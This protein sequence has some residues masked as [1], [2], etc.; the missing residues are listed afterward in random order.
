MNL[1]SDFGMYYNGTIIFTGDD[2]HLPFLVSGVEGGETLESLRFYGQVIIDAEGRTERRT[3]AYNDLDLNLPDL[4]W[5][6][7]NGSP[8]WITYKTVK[9]VRKGLHPIR[10]DGFHDRDFNRQNIWSLFQDFEGRISDDWCKIGDDLMFKRVKVGSVNADGSYDLLPGAEYLVSRL[11]L[12]QPGSQI[13][14]TQ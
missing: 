12:Q 2:A 10:L 4:G 3:I 5:R 9:T 8:K 7:V 13:N 1:S 11:E 14:I 6:L